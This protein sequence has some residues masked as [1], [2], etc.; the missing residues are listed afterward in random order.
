MQVLVERIDEVYIKVYTE[1]SIHSEL[2]D[3]FTF[4]VPGARF[5][6]KVKN[7]IWDGKIRLYNIQTNTIYAGLLPNIKEFCQLNDYEFIDNASHV[8]LSISREKILEYVVDKLK[9]LDSSGSPL[10]PYSYQIEAISHA[11]ENNRAVLVS[12]TNSGKSLIIYTLLR[13]FQ[14]FCLKPGQKIL[15]I[16]PTTSLVTQLFSDFGEYSAQDSWNVDDYVHKIYEGA[17]KD[18]NKPIVISTWQSIY[19]QPKSW[20]DPFLV[21]FGDECHTFKAK[22]LMNIMTKL[23]ECK[24]RIGLTGTLDD[25]QT[26]ILTLTGLFGKPVTIVRSHEMIKLGHS[27][28]L[29]IKALILDHDVQS[30]ALLKKSTYPEEIDWILTHEK[31]N[32]LLCKLALAKRTIHYFCFKKKSM[33]NCSIIY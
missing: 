25:S 15:I 16:V 32:K 5:N 24:H 18:T 31:R 1:R 27:S 22:S 29:N 11:I 17:T 19:E 23:T 8:Q 12:A 4:M 2:R 6:P 26:H 30:R 9:P 7:K 13:F 10:V 33:E 3:Y 14:R 21:T 28:K 20:F